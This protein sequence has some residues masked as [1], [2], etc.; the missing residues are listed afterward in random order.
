M[1]KFFIKS[2][3]CKQNQLEGQIIQNELEN[4]GYKAI[5]SIKEADI[6]ILNSCSVTSHS[7][8]QANYLLNHAKRLNPNIKTILTGCCAQTHERH[9]DFNYS[10]IDL[11]LGN[12]EK[13]HIEKYIEKLFKDKKD[14]FVEDIFNQKEFDNKFLINP[15]TTRVS[16]KIQDGCNNRCSYCII[17]YARGNSRSNSI[18]NIIKQIN[19]VIEKGIKE[20]VLTGIHIGQWGL[21]NNQTLLDL[22]KEI[23]KTDIQR[24]RLGSLYINELDDDF[25]KFL[26]KSEK[27][28]PHFHLSLQ[29]LCDKTL[30]NMNRKYTSKE[31]LEVIEKLHQ[32][33]NLPFLGCDIIVGFPQESEEDF[34]ETYNNLKLA[35]LSAIHCFPY[36]KREGTPAYYSKNQVQNS[37]KTK[38]CEL[39]QNLSKELH[40]EFLE[41]NKDTNAEILIEKKSPKTGLYSAITRNYIKIN[42][43]NDDNNLRHTLKTVNLS[44]FE[45]M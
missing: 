1:K 18:E 19:I 34:L 41:K 11:V 29:S 22:L 9:K 31:A 37:I 5:N 17:P 28:C 21:E 44:D 25:I 13:I 35:K 43:K 14:F 42:F 27:F 7:D 39:V 10:D 16:I 4:L 32:N 45:L 2:L 15:N 26:S 24:Y 40:Q 33:F 3:G 12:I 36:S 20:I 23:E 6:Y 30:H 8:S 38:R